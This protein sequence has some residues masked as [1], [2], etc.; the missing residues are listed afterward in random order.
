[1]EDEKVEIVR[2]PG[3]YMVDGKWY[4]L[5]RDEN[6]FYGWDNSWHPKSEEDQMI[7]RSNIH[8]IMGMGGENTIKIE[9][10]SVDI[11]EPVPIKVGDEVEYSGLLDYGYETG[12]VEVIRD[13][14]SACSKEYKINGEWLSDVTYSIHKKVDEE[15]ILYGTVEEV[16]SGGMNSV[17]ENHTPPIFRTP[18]EI[19]EE[20]R[21]FSEEGNRT[22][23]SPPHSNIKIDRIGRD[24]SRKHQTTIDED[25][26]N[27]LI[28]D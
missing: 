12:I 17:N 15:D 5:P 14:F 3:A 2:V 21:K 7:E 26:M 24:N 19:I 9:V 1:M 20:M 27:F 4:S 13:N 28:E 18:E 23:V 11:K 6:K 16:I 25:L 10:K 22:I 8:H